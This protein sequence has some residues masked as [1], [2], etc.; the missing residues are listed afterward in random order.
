M[1]RP[2]LLLASAALLLTAAAPSSAR[3]RHEGRFAP[4]GAFTSFRIVELAPEQLELELASG[5]TMCT[6]AI[7]WWRERPLAVKPMLDFQAERAG[8]CAATDATFAEG[9]L[10]LDQPS[11]RGGVVRLLRGKTARAELRVD[12]AREVAP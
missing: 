10:T 9:A 1:N 5:K 11:G 2:L 12:H 7:T 6:F 8:P 4:D 3:V